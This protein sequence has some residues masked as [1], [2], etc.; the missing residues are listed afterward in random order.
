MEKN[1]VKLA[2]YELM[3]SQGMRVVISNLG[4]RIVSVFFVDIFGIERDVVLG[5]D[6]VDD[7]LPA[8]HR[9]DFGAVVGRYA[10][11]IAGGRFS[12]DGRS[13][14]LP[15]NDGTNCLHGGPEGWQY[16]IYDVVEASPT[17]IVMCLTSPD[18]D[19]GFPGN[20]RLTVT[21]TLSDDNALRIDYHAT[22]DKATA[23]NVTNHTYFNLN[24]VDGDTSVYNHVVYIDA[25]RYLPV[26]SRMIPSGDP[27]PL[28]GTPM[29]LRNP[30]M[31]TDRNIDSH[32]QLKQAGG[33]DLCYV[34]NHPGDLS[35]PVARVD[36][37]FR[38]IALEV[39]TDQPGIQLY[40]GNFL[41]GVVG[42]YGT[43]Y[44]YQYGLCLET[45]H[46]PDSPNHQW[47]ESPG[48][49]TPDQAFDSTTIFRFSIS[50][51]LI[52]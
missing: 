46:Y 40:T 4:A 39:F 36:C 28:D 19:S 31:I 38:S 48:I 21:Y 24:G 50:D 23:F 3:N 6:N 12:I 30:V 18:G 22:T 41:D 5:F 51:M 10:N 35:R 44:D 9:S 26:D 47:P 11:R 34:L 1:N 17:R 7:Y 33:F 15:Q 45:Q 13:Y 27:I 43:A 14:Q 52:L 29:D 8:N 20:V 42:K 32:P 16:A 49:I 37:P 2:L 25:D